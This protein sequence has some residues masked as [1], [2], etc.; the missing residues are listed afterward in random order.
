M[1]GHNHIRTER[2]ASMYVRCSDNIVQSRCVNPWFRT[3]ANTCSTASVSGFTLRNDIIVDHEHRY[4]QC[5]PHFESLANDGLSR[6]PGV[7]RPESLGPWVL[8][9]LRG[10]GHRMQ[11][12]L[13][14]F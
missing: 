8:D 10:E 14:P 13:T 2:L 4:G 9:L 5:P 12:S 7:A 11:V 3:S 1:H 6:S